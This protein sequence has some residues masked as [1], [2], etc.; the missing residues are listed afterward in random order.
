MWKKFLQ[1]VTK[2]GKESNIFY[3]PDK[4]EMKYSNM[5]E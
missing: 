3:L 2:M 5:M 1:L 4:K